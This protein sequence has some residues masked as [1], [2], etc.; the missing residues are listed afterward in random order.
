M[1]SEYIVD[2]HIHTVLSPCGELEMGAPEIIA[3]VREQGIDVIA[4]TD[5]NECSN[6]KALQ[7]AAGSEGP[8]VLPGIEVQTAEDI[9]IVVVFP[10]LSEAETFQAWLRQGFG[11]TRNRPEV[12]GYQLM[13]DQYNNIL[14]QID[15]L[16]I[17]GVTYSI[18]EVIKRST[19]QN[20]LKILA[21]IDRPSFSF[22][23]VLGPIPPE[24]NVDAFEVSS[25]V[26]VEIAGEIQR[27]YPDRTILRS[28]DSH[29]L[30]TISKA[31]CSRMLLAEPTFKEI[32]MAIKGKEGRTVIWPW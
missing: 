10:D 2:L 1:F 15:T 28:S 18:D 9:H 32:V 29:Q 23:A 25:Q 20:A 19:L 6:V 13:I 27:S 8:V 24:I 4:I 3:R 22:P 7:D 12:F 21:H 11:K 30:K 16:L 31:N 5:H 17:Q 26:P 14:K